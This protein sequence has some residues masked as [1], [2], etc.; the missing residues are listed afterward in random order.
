MIFT[1]PQY[2]FAFINGY[3]GQTLYDDF[4]ITLYNLIFTSI[5]LVVRAIL[6]QDINFVTRI[7]D[8]SQ[9]HDQ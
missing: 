7:N 2:L 8:K 9:F 4:Y 1:I 3:S 6:E 5:P